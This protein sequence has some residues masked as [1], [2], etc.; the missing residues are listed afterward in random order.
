M[1]K[2]SYYVF[3]THK[4]RDISKY[5][6]INIRKYYSNLSYINIIINNNKTIKYAQI[7]MSVSDRIF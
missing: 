1:N 3:S 5:I 7:S 6:L 2:K 4:D